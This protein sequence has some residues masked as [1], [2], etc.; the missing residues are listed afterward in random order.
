MS[1]IVGGSGID[2]SEFKGVALALKAAQPML[3]LELVR[4]LNA[5]GDLVAKDAAAIVAPYSESIPPTIKR[6]RRGVSVVVQAGGGRMW[7]YLPAPTSGQ[8][9]ESPL[10][11]LFEMGNK[12]GSKSAAATG[13][14]VFRHPVFNTGEWVDQEMHPFLSVAGKRNQA[15]V[16]ALVYEALDAVA[17]EIAHGFGGRITP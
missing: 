5:A 7:Q 12:G 17:E 16:D 1:T 11:G 15:K 2:T 3:R 4:S 10:A 6:R 14:G 9:E 8:V 13:R